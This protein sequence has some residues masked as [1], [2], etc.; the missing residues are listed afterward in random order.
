MHASAPLDILLAP[1][2]TVFGALSFD[3]EVLQMLRSFVL[4]STR[5]PCP[6]RQRNVPARV[7]IFRY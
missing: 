4:S 6:S 2:Q 5:L 3:Y 7:K 1:S